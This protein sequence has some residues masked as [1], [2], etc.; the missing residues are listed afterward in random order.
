[1]N[2][3]SFASCVVF[4]I[5]TAQAFFVLYL[6]PRSEVHRRF[7]AMT[8]CLSLWLF[9]AMW[10]YA[11]PTEERALLWFRICSP[12]FLFLHPATL[13]FCAT[14][15]GAV[16]RRR[17]LLYLL[18][19]PSIAFVFV[20]WTT[21]LVFRSFVRAGSNWIGITDYTSLSFHLLVVNY[22]SYYVASVA[23]LLRWRARTRSSRE[24]TQA[25]IVAVSVI[26]TVFLFNLEPF[27][28]PLVT[29]Y[30]SVV[31]SPILGVVWITGIGVAI[32]RYGLLSW[33]LSAAGADIIANIDESVVLLDMDLA[34]LVVNR[35]TYE[36]LGMDPG[37]R[38]PPPLSSIIRDPYALRK[39]ILE[40]REGKVAAFACR[41]RYAGPHSPLV[42]ARFSLTRDRHGETLGVLLVGRERKDEATFRRHF[43]LT[44]REVDVVRLLVQGLAIAHIA[45][46]LGVTPR[47]V[48]AHITHIY[49]KSDVR[50]KVGLFEL[51]RSYGLLP[52]QEAETSAFPLLRPPSAGSR[53]PD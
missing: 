35:R 50:N 28:L 31:V 11:A 27:I 8:L 3:L 48:K 22:V 19:L 15:T 6:D 24:K 9:G 20:S 49:A 42:D 12:G 53:N 7:C 29:T 51:V 1:M 21:H 40:L 33:T 39:D 47:T 38:A 37:T 52:E 30:R 41:L 5:A 23:L 46:R 2:P 4:C 43:T 18:Y 25:I 44:D 34:P 32:V 16:K 14:L 36:L 13:H 45:E 26:G 17:G 10:G